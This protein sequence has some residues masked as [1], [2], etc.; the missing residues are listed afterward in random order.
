MADVTAAAAELAKTLSG[1]VLVPADPRWD[2]MR[3]VHNGLVDRRPAVIAQCRG[4][5]DI[6]DAVR[7]AREQGL[8]IAVRGGGHNVGGRAT[9]DD[10]LMIDLSLMKHVHVDPA[11]ATARVAGGTLWGHFNREAQ[12][13]GLATTGGVVSTTGVAGLTLGGGFG[14]L[15]P[16]YGMALDNLLSVDIVLA[17]GTVTR[18]NADEHP[19]LHWA[20][21]GGGGNFGVVSSFEFRVHPVGPMVMGGLVAWPFDRARDVLRLYRDRCAAASDEMMV[22]GA[23]LTA[24]DGATKLVGIA[25]GHVGPA[26]DAGAALAPIKAFGQPVMDVM[27]P[28]PYTQ[29]NM[30]IDD[31]LPRGARNYWKSHFLPELTDEV[32]DLAIEAHGRCPSPMSQLL[33]ENFHGAATRVPPTDTAFAL[34]SPGFNCGIIGQ[35]MDPGA[36]AANTAWC[37]EVYQAIQPHVGPSRYLNYLDHDDTGDAALTAAYGP[38]VR[39]L[40]ALKAKYDPDNV[41]HHNVNIPPKA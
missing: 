38:N 28:I 9:I 29:L 10:G 8:E 41:F 24:P 15:M 19:D 11:H 37:R 12:V 14:W 39:R 6:A 36:D 13:H 20:V 32:I 21:R 30:I 16:K 34:R 23:L 25:A 27:G 17:D 31:A 1:P 4:T 7:F 3:R 33:F 5:A 22:V 40:Q 35:W 2:E 18:A 26:A